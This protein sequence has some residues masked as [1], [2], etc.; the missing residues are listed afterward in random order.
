MA[1]VF[2]KSREGKLEWTFLARKTNGV[3]AAEATRGK[4]KTAVYMCP[5]TRTL[6][7][8]GRSE[9]CR[10]VN[11]KVKH[12]LRVGAAFERNPDFG[13]LAFITHAQVP[14]CRVAVCLNLRS[15]RL[16]SK[17]Y[18]CL[19]RGRS[20]IQPLPLTMASARGSPC[21]S[22]LTSDPVAWMCPGS[23]T[24]PLANSTRITTEELHLCSDQPPSAAHV[25]NFTKFG[26]K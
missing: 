20:I 4:L 14:V 2:V 9:S 8:D 7:L 11:W 15:C 16:T 25:L 26:W 5:T 17:Y 10:R 18:P 21:L 23:T 1:G 12:N 22:Q 24:A 13:A 6:K 19:S 3:G